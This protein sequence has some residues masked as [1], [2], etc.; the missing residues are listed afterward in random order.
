MGKDESFKSD[1]SR[2]QTPEER[3]KLNLN[4]SDLSLE[5][6]QIMKEC[7][8]E[9]FWY[10]CVPFSMALIGS[11]QYLTYRGILKPHPRYGA[12]FKNMAAGLG[13]FILGKISYLG[14]CQE[15]FLKSENSAFGQTLRNSK[16]GTN[17]EM[18][19]HNEYL[20]RELSTES[21]AQKSNKLSSYEQLRAQNRNNFDKKSLDQS[22]ISPNTPNKYSNVSEPSKLR[23]SGKKNKYGDEISNDD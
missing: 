3:V 1:F 15:K 11:T 9:S 19:D 13:G 6:L 20:H 21:S 7:N 4:R 14:N 12:L 16:K 2:D 23:I 17:T 5:D 18:M 8:K 10:R 22:D